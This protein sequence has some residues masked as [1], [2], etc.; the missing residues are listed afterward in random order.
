MCLCKSQN[1]IQNISV[2]H[3]IDNVSVSHKKV[4]YRVFLRGADRGV[5]T[6]VCDGCCKLHRKLRNARI[7]PLEVRILQ[8]QKISMSFHGQ[9]GKYSAY[10]SP[11]YQNSFFSKLE[12]CFLF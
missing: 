11:L 7:Y 1:T 4:I 3:K 8:Q 2:N 6:M 10:L 12:Y 9:L 5:L